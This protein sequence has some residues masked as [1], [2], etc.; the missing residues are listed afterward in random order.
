MA[1]FCSVHFAREK[2][3]MPF[4]VNT[5]KSPYMILVFFF[6][7]CGDQEGHKVVHLEDGDVP[8]I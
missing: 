4:W 1:N 2:W 3:H 6:S 8:I 5:K 7:F